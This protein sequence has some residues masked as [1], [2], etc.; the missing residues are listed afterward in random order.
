MESS[1]NFL[2]YCYTCNIEDEKS[3]K[4]NTSVDDRFYKIII[5][6]PNKMQI[7]ISV[8]LTEMKFKH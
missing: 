1:S 6:A 4:L 2:H 5:M 8:Y 7:D 3:E